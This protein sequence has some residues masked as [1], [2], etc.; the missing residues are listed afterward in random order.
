MCF[1]IQIRRQS[2]KSQ[3][4]IRVPKPRLVKGRIVERNGV[5]L[6]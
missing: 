5:V 2:V 3:V 1:R 6:E 4:S